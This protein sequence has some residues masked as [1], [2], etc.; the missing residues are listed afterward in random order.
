MFDQSVHKIGL[1]IAISCGIQKKKTF[2]NAESSPLTK[3]GQTITDDGNIKN[4]LCF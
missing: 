4:S 1:S 2:I 3:K